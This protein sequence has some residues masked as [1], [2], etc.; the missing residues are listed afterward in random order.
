MQS[1]VS[2]FIKHIMFSSTWQDSHSLDLRIRCNLRN[3]SVPSFLSVGISLKA[4]LSSSKLCFFFWGGGRG[5]VEGSVF[6][7]MDQLIEVAFLLLETFFF[8]PR[9]NVIND[10]LVVPPVYY[11]AFWSTWPSLPGFIFEYIMLHGKRA[12]A[13][14][15]KVT[16]HWR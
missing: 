12:F 7:K 3:D 15:N 6:D 10:F 9:Q 13:E 11:T 1:S 8:Y 4:T 5:R 14:V 16:D 2:S